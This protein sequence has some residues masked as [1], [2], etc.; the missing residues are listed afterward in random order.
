MTR[1]KSRTSDRQ[2]LPDALR[3][4]ERL[5]DRTLLTATPIVVTNSADTLD[6]TAPAYV[7]SLRWAID[8]ANAAPGADVVQFNIPGGLSTIH[9]GS[10][11]RITDAVTLDGTTEPGYAD[12]PLIWL[13]GGGAGHTDFGL[14]LEGPGGSTVR[15]LG[16]SNFNLAA[17]DVRSGGNLIGGAA[18]GQGNVIVYSSADGVLVESG[19]GNV[20]QGNL[21]GTD[22]DGNRAENQRYGVLVTAAADQTRVADNFVGYNQ[23]AGIGID[24][25]GDVDVVGNYVGLGRQTLNGSQVF[26]PMGNGAAG[27]YVTGQ[28]AGRDVCVAGNV[29][30]LSDANGITLDAASG[31]RVTGNRIGTDPAGNYADGRFGN[32]GDGVHV[33]HGSTGNV[34][35]GTATGAGNIIT[36]SIGD[37]V[38]I[39]D[40]TGNVVAGNTITQNFGAGVAI[41]RG[42]GNV[43]ADG[44]ALYANYGVAIDLM[45]FLD[46]GDTTLWFQG[47]GFDPATTPSSYVAEPTVTSVRAR[48]AQTVVRGS[49]DAVPGQTYLVRVYASEGR[50]EADFGNGL[51]YF[52]EAQQY[53]GTITVTATGATARFAGAFNLPAGMTWLTATVTDAA[54]NTSEVSGA[55][56]PSGTEPVVATTLASSLN[57]SVIGQTVTLTA[58][59]TIDGADAADGSVLFMD[60]STLLGAGTKTAAG[61]W[62]FSTSSLAV[63]SHNLQAIY[64]DTDGLASDQPG[65]LTQTVAKAT[66]RT[67]L[68]VSASSSDLGH[69][70]TFTATVTVLDS[71]L[72]AAGAVTFYDG[73]TAIGTGT[74]SGGVATLT[75][76]ALGGGNHAITAGYGGSATHR[77]STSDPVTHTVNASFVASGRTLRDLTGNGLSADDTA[78]AGVTVKVFADS[79]NNGVLDSRDAVVSTLVTDG[80][81]LFTLSVTTPGTYFAQEVTPT[82]YAQ[83]APAAGYY[84]FTAVPGGAAASLDFANWQVKASTLSG[85]VYVDRDND[86][87]KESGENGLSGVTIL[88]KGAAGNVVATTTTDCNGAYTFASVMPGTYTLVEVQP[89]KYVD[90]I[91]TAGSLGGDAGGDSNTITAIPVGSGQSGTG[92]DFG[93]LPETF[94]C[95]GETATIGFW[96]NKNGQ[97]LIKS[98]NGG[99][100]SKALASWLAGTLPNL[101]GAGSPNS[102]VGK[103][104]ADV[105]TLFT[106]LFKAGGQ[107]LDAQVLAV[108]LAVY[109]TTNTLGGTAAARYGF[110]VDAIGTGHRL[111]N[112]GT[113][114]AAFGVANNTKMEVL[115]ILTAAD[116][117]AVNGVLYGGN[118]GLRNMANNV[119]SGINEQGDI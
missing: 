81:G 83:T 16:F 28:F 51:E 93:E 71:P 4:L 34:I 100:T 47:P 6:T 50:Y 31:V 43:V 19:A 117:R 105:A 74:L 115:D 97:A 82:G 116:A 8:Q 110:A 48:G 69:S 24:G 96:Q 7:G 15:G 5:E 84:T 92:Y 94:V 73:G 90:G 118:S 104:N 80:T 9:L 60:G 40:S 22:A 11:L 91:E 79:N 58:H 46:V 30:V 85:Y 42:S 64:V 33:D 20:V 87:V 67:T 61:L 77:G 88:L 98:F 12:A 59:V 45:D 57:P 56:Q 18:A 70:V 2:S 44:N 54:G 99:Q 107:K 63:G 114:A 66:T 23:V 103:T 113:N 76:S 32:F 53:L 29:V 95:S 25:A 36:G 27:I 65:T 13:D 39:M 38:R 106:K 102:L 41:G 35:G 21:I 1:R 68:A 72:D 109:S 26:I 108:A 75:T 52:G 86:G 111:Y 17:I 3:G 49:F 119:F 112:I 55:M 78:M 89:A 10:K 14:S 37:G 62:T 101:Y